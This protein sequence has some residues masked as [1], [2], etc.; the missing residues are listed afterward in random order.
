[1]TQCSEGKQ[2]H[3]GTVGGRRSTAPSMLPATLEKHHQTWGVN[4]TCRRH[5]RESACFV[6]QKMAKTGDS[7]KQ[8]RTDRQPA[9]SREVCRSWNENR[10]QYMLCRPTHVCNR[11]E[12]NHLATVCQWPPVKLMGPPEF[13]RERKWTG[14]A[15]GVKEG[16]R[17]VYLM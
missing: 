3:Q 2:Q 6:E 4:S 13:K 17:L 12:G 7:H 5:I 10:C 14:L 11:F 9:P 16:T 15:S 1:M 8:S